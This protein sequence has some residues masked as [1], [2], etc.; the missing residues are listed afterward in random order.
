[1]PFLELSG[2]LLEH[3]LPHGSVKA[4]VIEPL[5]AEKNHEISRVKK[6]VFFEIFGDSKITGFSRT[7][8]LKS[9]VFHASFTLKSRLMI[10]P[11]NF[12]F[13]NLSVKIAIS[14]THSL[15]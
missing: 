5:A 15:S 7:I 14:T 9:R 3:P 12:K 4:M 11:E 8:T 6:S 13:S 10:F 1:M 2:G